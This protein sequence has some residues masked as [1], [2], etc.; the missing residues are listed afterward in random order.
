MS[1]V[2]AVAGGLLS[3]IGR[4]NPH[5]WPNSALSLELNESYSVLDRGLHFRHL[6]EL[7][8]VS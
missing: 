5:K 7:K 8:R 6:Y 1:T 2:Q 4:L 3:G